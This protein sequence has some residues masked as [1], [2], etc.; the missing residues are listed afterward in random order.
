MMPDQRLLA[1]LE[2]SGGSRRAETKFR[3]ALPAERRRAGLSCCCCRAWPARSL[4]AGCCSGVAARRGRYW[5]WRSGR[6]LVGAG[7]AVRT[8]RTALCSP[9]GLAVHQSGAAP[10]LRRPLGTS[11]GRGGSSA[12]LHGG[13]V[14]VTLQSFRGGP[15]AC[16]GGGRINRCDVSRMDGW[17]DLHAEREMLEIRLLELERA[18][19]ERQRCG[20]AAPELADNVVDLLDRLRKVNAKL[21]KLRALQQPHSLRTNRQDQASAM[22]VMAM[23]DAWLIPWSR[24]TGDTEASTSR[25]W[26]C[27]NPPANL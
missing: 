1:R 19:G 15:W 9:L 26:R 14:L 13:D 5:L 24:A 4:S 21:A 2:P 7:I 6:A 17:T 3:H 12:S 8:A 16:P 25:C 20:V 22:S 27:C 11:R 18:I 23:T 10:G